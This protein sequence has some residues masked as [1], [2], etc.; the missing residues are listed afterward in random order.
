MSNISFRP[1]VREAVGLIVG[2]C[3]GTGSGK[4][5]SAMEMAT[6]ICGA[7]SFALIDT[8]NRRGLHYADA[9][10]FDHA[11]LRAPFS[12]DAYADAIIA[13]DKAGYKVIVVDS[14]THEWAG[15]GGV[16]DMQEAE[17][18]RMAGTDW[19]K[20]E[21]CKMAAWIKPKMA[22]KHMVSKL[23]QVRAHLILCF[24]AEEKVEMLRGDD[25][26]MKIVPKKSLTGL[27]GWMPVCEKNLPFEL[28]ASFLL[29]ADQPG[30]PKPIKLQQQHRNLF[31]LDKPINRESGRLV[32]AWAAGG[33]AQAATISPE[34]Q[35]PA[36]AP[37]SQP[38]SQSGGL[39]DPLLV[40][41]QE[42]AETGMEGYQ[43]FWSGL[44]AEQRKQVGAE[45]HTKFKEI[46]AQT[47]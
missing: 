12:P 30:F 23:L 20:R 38:S 9:F 11:D 31:P 44:S 47:K 46:A 19:K 3:G 1:A 8:E 32:A 10:K 2:L 22:H 27:D 18:D 41:C 26:K 35:S 7:D 40:K 39:P 17:L 14:A 33:T 36:G 24:R 4:T 42:W 43:K 28:T 34:G 21:S 6:G 25:G 13:A 16:L 5:W 37:P 15:D 29:T 45:R